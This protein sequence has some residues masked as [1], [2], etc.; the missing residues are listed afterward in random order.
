MLKT[1]NARWTTTTSMPI[2]IDEKIA[3]I[4]IIM[5]MNAWTGG[6]IPQ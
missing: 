2:G 4:C 1:T 5:L 6:I 3:Y